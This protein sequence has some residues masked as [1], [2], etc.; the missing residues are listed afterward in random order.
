MR[1]V[2]MVDD[3]ATGRRVAVF[4]LRKAGFEVDEAADGEAAL[5]L[6][7]PARHGAVVTDLK[8]PRRDGMS[9]LKAL[10]RRT[11]GLPVVVITAYGSVDR[12]VDAMQAGAWDFLEKPF[13]R[14]RLTVTV[15]R[16][17]EAAALREDNRRLKAAAIERPIIAES[18]AMR[19]AL[20]QA[21]R[22]AAASIPVLITGESGTGKELFARRIHARSARV[23]GPF[24]AV[25]CAAIPAELL[26]SEMFGH[27]KG[28]FSGAVRERPGRFRRADGGTLFLDE[29]GDMPAALQA[30]LLRA[31]EEGT[32]DVVGDDEPVRVDVRVV[33]ATNQ[34]LPARIAGGGFRQDLYYRLAGFELS[35]PPLRERPEDVL[36]LAQ[37]FLEAADPGRDLALPAE[38]ARA[39]EG[40]DWPG[41][42]RELRSACDRLALL[43][44]SGEVS[45][46]HLPPTSGGRLDPVDEDWPALVPSELGLLD[47]EVLVIT[48]ALRR[49]GW[50]LSEASRRLKVPRHILAY[51]VEKHGI[52]RQD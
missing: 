5:A 13:G 29:V 36:P 22:V 25:N 52:V 3:D 9:L 31:L 7:D 35:L 40:R 20:K 28:A 34:D 24:V 19:A 14:E 38:V 2:L 1:A 26:E 43:A 33:S 21:D 18:A 45:A 41:N 32:I 23:G 44:D 48:H 10:L 27:R 51:R 4:N 37:A 6:Y 8:M 30:K 11:P 12:A 15:R 50:N 16:A 39:L 17:L 47:I 46:E 49:C 42:V